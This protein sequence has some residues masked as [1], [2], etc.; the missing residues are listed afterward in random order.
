MQMG[1]GSYG[2]C[3]MNAEAAKVAVR[4]LGLAAVLA[5]QALRYVAS[6]GVATGVGRGCKECEACG[7]GAQSGR[8]QVRSHGSW[9]MHA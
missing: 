3:G 4:Q 7:G 9:M 2:L 8:M 5:L 1:S 6:M